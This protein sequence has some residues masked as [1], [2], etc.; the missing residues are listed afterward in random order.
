MCFKL[1]KT[2]VESIN[3]ILINL[4]LVVAFWCFLVL[5]GAC[6]ILSL[7]RKEKFK[8][9]LITSYIL[10]LILDVTSVTEFDIK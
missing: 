2:Y 1:D 3:L 5:F 7:K 8:T 9:G 10:L 4:K 6:I